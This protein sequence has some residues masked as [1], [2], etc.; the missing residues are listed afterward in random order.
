MS[1]WRNHKLTDQ[2]QV[3][4][5]LSPAE[6]RAIDLVAENPQIIVREVIESLGLHKSTLTSLLDRLEK[7]GYIKRVISPRDR[8]SF[9]LELTPQGRT[10]YEAHVTLES[11]MWQ[12]ALS[13]LDGGSEQAAFVTCLRKMTNGLAECK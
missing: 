10:A 1:Q 4:H 9:G 11:E 8:R 13:F 3:L 5:D 2:F 6:T 12:R 7:R